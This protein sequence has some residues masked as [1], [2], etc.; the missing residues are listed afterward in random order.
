[1]YEE[2][3]QTPQGSRASEAE[4]PSFDA[5][6]ED[7]LDGHEHR[8]L[9]RGDIVRGEVVYIGEEGL[10][11]DVGAKSEG[12]VPFSDLERSGVAESLQEGDS[13]L[14]YCV[15]PED[16][17]GNIL[18]SISK[19]QVARD[20]E[21]AKEIY[22]SGDIF[23]TK[24]AGHNKGGVI[25]YLGKVRGFVPASQ[26]AHHRR[27]QYQDSDAAHPWSELMGE[28][29]WLKVIECDPEQ[30]RLILSEQAALRQRRKSMRA[31]LLS[32]LQEGDVVTGEVTSLA[33]FGAFVDLGGADGLIHVSE[34]SWDRVKHP[35]E[36]LNIGDE[37]TVQVISID[38]ERKR[39]GLSM[40]RLEP[41]PWSVIDE[42]YQVG[43]LVTGTITKLTNFGAFARIEGGIEGLIHI[44]ELTDRMIKH[45]SEVVEA[46]DE[47]PLRI[48]RIEPERRRIG[49]SLRQAE[50]EGPWSEDEG[51]LEEASLAEDAVVSTGDEM[52]V[53][54]D[55]P[56]QIEAES[57]DGEA[58]EEEPLHQPE[59]LMERVAEANVDVE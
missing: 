40:K 43:D 20:W 18:L 30:N 16:R 50:E 6:M 54:E 31:E 14:V 10:M 27:T 28:E 56:D 12:I 38:D 42:R 29:L 9:R 39:I 5:S 25:V 59:G 4:I 7:W 15:T 3:T 46:G 23:Q 21:R 11:V 17:N 55:E 35:S 13:V 37:V 58:L 41:E 45:P 1:M 52:L 48:I 33:D 53:I 22:D 34:L 8:V 49:L 32:S 36:V 2:E 51:A 57:E 24:V 19:A 47:V 26:L 44:S